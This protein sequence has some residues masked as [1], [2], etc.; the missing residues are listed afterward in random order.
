[1][2]KKRFISLLLLLFV[3][4]VSFA[5][6]QSDVNGKQGKAGI[7]VTITQM[8]SRGHELGTGLGPFFTADCRYG[9]TFISFPYEGFTYF[10]EPGTLI[11]HVSDYENM[12]LS[13]TITVNGK[14]IGFGRG[15]YT[16]DINSETVVE[17]IYEKN[18]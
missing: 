10:S 5:T 9:D 16:I 8:D 6:N 13:R 2:K 11:L 3:C 14:M 4:T 15:T 17:I 1:M 18:F 12:Y 7:K